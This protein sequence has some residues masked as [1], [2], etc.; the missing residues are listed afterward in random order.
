MSSTGVTRSLPDRVP[1]HRGHQ[2]ARTFERSNVTPI[3]AR[4][5][6]GRVLEQPS[7]ANPIGDAAFRL[8]QWRVDPALNEIS[9]DDTTVRLEPRT[10]RL[11]VCLAEHAGDVVNV[12]QLLDT[13]WKDLVVTQCSVYQAVAALRR[14]LGDDRKNPTYIA[15]VVRRGYRLVAPVSTDAQVQD[16]A[17]FTPEPAAA[18]DLHTERALAEDEHQHPGPDLPAASE[19]AERGRRL[20]YASILLALLVLTGSVWWFFLRLGQEHL[21]RAAAARSPVTPARVE[22]PSAFTPPRH[23]VAVL[24]FSNLSGE[25]KDEYFSDGMSEELINALTQINALKVIARTS[26]FSFRGKDADIGTIARK[27]NVAAILEGSVRRSGNKVRITAQLIDTVSGF[28]IWSHDYDR[29]LDDVLSLQTDIARAVAGELQAKLLGDE[30]PKME[31][32]GTHNPAAFDAYLRGAKA[33][34][35]RADARDCQTAGAAYT[36]A[37]RLD[38]KYALAF[39]ARS[40]AHSCYAEE[41]AT[42]PAVREAFDQAQAD[43]R[44]AVALAPELAE[45]HAAL[46]SYLASGA[47]DYAAASE[48]YRRAVTFA[49]GNAQVLRDSGRFAGFM[50]HFD[51]GLAATH[52]AVLLDPLNPRSHSMLGQV[53]LL[54][55]RYTEAI[56]AFTEVISLDPSDKF[57]IGYRGLAYY[58]VGDLAGA[59]ASCETKPDHWATQ[60]CLAITYDKLGRHADAEAV[61]ARMKATYGDAASYQYATIYAQWGDARKS[62][63]WLATALRV[64]DPG[65]YY[66]KTDPLLDPLRKEPRFQAIERALKLPD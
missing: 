55:R 10:M 29:D 19:S 21:A 26:S 3:P 12:N 64:R 23:S 65:L 25:P 35:T 38:P 60:W 43:A 48:E 63:E 13:V 31:L 4:R 6:T 28:H 58:G 42:G 33:Y 15:S 9:R 36:E 61:V 52:R 34:S 22:P 40:S 1:E 18:A 2:L 45:A 49:P 47:Q 24:P 62:L 37:I 46:G 16:P 44:R 7:R 56:A 41:F 32:G 20:R 50:G 66:V 27:L 17:A 53:L 30:T 39:A 8:G 54:A 51:A 59:R 14:A 11:L 57:A 5:S